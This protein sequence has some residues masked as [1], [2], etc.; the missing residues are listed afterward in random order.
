MFITLERII[1]S[2]LKN[3]FRNSLLSASSVLIMTITLIVGLS[4]FLSTNMIKQSIIQFEK[5]V[6]INIYFQPDAPADKVIEF[7]K[8]VEALPEVDKEK[9]VFTPKDKVLEDFKKNTPE[10]SI[11]MEVLK[12]ISPENPLGAIL[13]I[14]A[15][16]IGAYKP[17]TDFI[18]SRDVQIKYGDLVKNLDYKQNK[19]AINKLNILVKNTYK[20]GFVVSLILILTSIVITFNTMRLIIYTHKEEISVMRLVG[21]SKFF[22]RGPFVVEGI[23]YGIVSAVF[24]LFISWAAVFYISPHLN[25]VFIL[26]INEFFSSNILKIASGMLITGIILGFISTYLAVSKYL[27]V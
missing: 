9:T 11:N 25:E 2:G 15:K 6:D 21:S 13:N 24:A 16:K 10:N 14:K 26:N 22:A 12:I 19:R 1:K 23:I 3:F 8:M 20:I 5:K 17:I 18:E 27:K 4:I 7:K